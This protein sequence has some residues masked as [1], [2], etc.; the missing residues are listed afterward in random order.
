VALRF[1]RGIKFAVSTEKKMNVLLGI[2]SVIFFGVF[3][4]LFYLQILNYPYYRGLSDNNSL[5]L[6]TARAPRGI[7]T[8]RNGE[9]L[10]TNEPS[11][12]LY[13]V[14]ADLKANT[15]SL[16]RLSQILDE[17]LS[18]LELMVESRKKR[19]RFEPI[20]LQT[21]LDEKMIA[22][23]EENRVRLPGVYV[24]QEPE[25]FYPHGELASHIL[26]Y[27]GEISEED[28]TRLRENG[29]SVGAVVGKNG[30]ERVYDQVLRG[31][32]GG[33]Q[34]EVDASGI[35]RR[36]LA[37]KKP[38]QGQTLQ[39]SIDWKIQELAEKLMGD[40]IGSVVVTN[41]QTGEILALVSHPNFDPN[42]FV[43]GISFK[44]WN[45]LLKDKNHPLEDR[46]IQGQYP[47]GSIFKLV[48]TLGALEDGVIDFNK[49]FLCKGIFW[50]KTWPYRCWRTSGH[51]W[52][53][54]ER[55]II[56][57]CD[58]FFYQLGLLVKIDKIYSVAKEM[59]LGSKTQVDLDHELSGLVPNP[60]WK[61]ATQHQPWFPGNTIQM[62][63]G[64]G[65]LLT[66]P[67]QMLDVTAGLA[68]NGKIFKPHLLYRIVDQNTGR[69]VFEKQ[70]EVLHE[71]NVD[72]KYLDFIKATME[73]VINSEFGTGKKARIRGVRVAGKTGTSENPHGD[74]HAWFTAFAPA[75][76]PKV[77][78]IVMVENGG[79]GG[80]VSAPI[81]KRVMEQTLGL[82]VTPWQ[83]P[84]P[85]VPQGT[86]VLKTGPVMG[87]A[88]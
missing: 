73:K 26:G 32:D 5:R 64:Q 42:E 50:F 25:R 35:Q 11:Y 81:A 69:T 9:I 70:P 83:T 17:P 33:V 37:Y 38:I 48:T 40:Q 8:D 66:T 65:Y 7:I 82:D 45:K 63:I 2:V 74:N 18:S 14:P 23:I 44:D 80:I 3:L 49:V 41:P 6:I 76:D 27:I 85:V 12:S 29:Y 57:S 68:M 71:S 67:L 78:I 87:V 54:L 58:I 59:G 30:I 46:A 88:P 4:K 21:H 77:A 55:A 1:P 53:N 43:S 31:E 10:A 79:E 39:L 34:I 84:T 62:S 51:G 52:V 15:N 20:R 28:L 13:V 56:E 75:E 22:E 72:K 47:P 36:T 86:P 24:Q 19:R 61:E 60:Q 16:V